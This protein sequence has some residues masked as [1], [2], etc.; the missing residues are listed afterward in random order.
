MEVGDEDKEG[1]DDTDGT[2]LFG[3]LDGDDRT[4]RLGHYPCH[5]QT[6]EQLGTLFGGPR[7]LIGPG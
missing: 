3:G 7:H 2:D 5:G 6:G 1:E 4:H